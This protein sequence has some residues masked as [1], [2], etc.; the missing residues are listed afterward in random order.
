MIN[1]I[2]SGHRRKNC[3][4]ARHRS[5]LLWQRIVILLGRSASPATH[6]NR[7]ALFQIVFSRAGLRFD[8]DI[9]RCER[10]FT[11][12]HF[13]YFFCLSCSC[14]AD[15]GRGD[16]D[17]CLRS[18]EAQNVMKFVCDV[19]GGFWL[20]LTAPLICARKQKPLAESDLY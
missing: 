13:G 17:P 16:E 14:V 20:L 15:G 10:E 19:W 18:G 6:R 12:G 1:Q 11:G 9:E 7:T 5:L 4:G 2:S 3:A 8:E